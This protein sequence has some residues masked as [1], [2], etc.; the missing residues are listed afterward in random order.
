[1]NDEDQ[2]K[3]R[4]YYHS[5]NGI[6]SV[7]NEATMSSH[8]A[9]GSLV[10]EYEKFIE[11]VNG[12]IPNILTAFNKRDFFSHDKYY[13]ADGI[14]LHIARNLG[15]LKVRADNV[16]DTPVTENKDFGFISNE[17]LRKIIQRDYQEIQ[18]GMISGNWK[19]SIILCGGAIETVLLDVVQRDAAT[20]HASLKAPSE[21]DFNKWNLN[22]LIEVALDTDLVDGQAASLSHTLRSYRNLVHPGVELRLGLKIEPEEAKIALQVLN[23][24]IR[25]LS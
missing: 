5:L 24:L 7:F 23:I 3:I 19:S 14:R 20:A 22:D 15:T 17:D 10:N 11:E 18:R 25:D 2:K 16:N 12:Q 4:E 21:N 13:H 1:M 9:E 6:K 8:M